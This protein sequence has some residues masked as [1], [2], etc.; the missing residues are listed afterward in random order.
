ML[1]YEG[2]HFYKIGGKYYVFFIHS[3][4]DRWKRVEACFVADSIDGEFVGKDVFNDDRGYC[5]QGVAQGGIVDTPDGKWYSIM[6]QDSGA[7]GRIPVLVPVNW[8]EDPEVGGRMFPVF[9]VDGVTPE[10]FD[11]PNNREGYEY[12]S[13]VASDD[14]KGTGNKEKYGTFGLKSAWQFNHDPDMS[15]VN[16]DR[17]NGKLW[18][19]TGKVCDTLTQANNV[20]T[21]RMSYPSCAAEV[22]LDITQLKEG[23][24]AG[25]CA[26]QG[27]FG[28]VGVTKRDDKFY[29][30]MNGKKPAPFH[31]A[32]DKEEDKEPACGTEY[33]SVLL[34]NA[35]DTIRLKI[36]ADFTNM[37]DTAKFYFSERFWWKKIGTNHQLRFSLDHFTGCRFGLFIY[38]TKEAGGKAGF[39]NFVYKQR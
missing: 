25:L 39:A 5:G 2:S 34:E 11:V 14:F 36:E 10:E 16:V 27:A 32:P 3:L 22:V 31:G 37:K 38:S 20:L 26:F 23:D 19:Q 35:G 7:I 8:E 18:I 1:G 29:M 15:L 17:E 6:F 28:F 12:T 9:G 13:L 24:V 33:E 21:Q 30:V 4:K